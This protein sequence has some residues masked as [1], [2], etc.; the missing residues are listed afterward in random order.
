MHWELLKWLC[1]CVPVVGLVFAV[2]TVPSSCQLLNCIFIAA[3]HT[4]QPSLRHKIHT[5]IH[6]W[7]KG[8]QSTVDSCSAD[9]GEGAGGMK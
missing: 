5:R 8:A 6:T 7:S 1:V 3:L 4:Q 9:T 2:V